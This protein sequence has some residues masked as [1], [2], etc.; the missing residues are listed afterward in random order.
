MGKDGVHRIYPTNGSALSEYSTVDRYSFFWAV[1]TIN[2]G[3]YRLYKHFLSNSVSLCQMFPTSRP[4]STHLLATIFCTIRRVLVCV[5]DMA[6]NLL[7]NDGDVTNRKRFQCPLLWC[8]EQ[9]TGQSLCNDIYF[10][11]TD[12]GTEGYTCYP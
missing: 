3:L 7:T 9:R 5:Y 10:E 12:S 6:W 11:E 4:S 1:S 8:N 2:R